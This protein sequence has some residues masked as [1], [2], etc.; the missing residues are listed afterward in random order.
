MKAP[1]APAMM[2]LSEGMPDGLASM[3]GDLLERA[4]ALSRS[5]VLAA[6]P[7]A[8]ILDVAERAAIVEV[9]AGAP[10]PVRTDAGDAVLVIATGRVRVGDAELG[11]GALIG[12]LAAVD[13]DAAPPDAIAVEPT[14]AIRIWQDDFL[15]LLA[16]HPA[17]ARTLARELAAALRRRTG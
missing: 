2:S 9:A 8:A 6:V 15:D 11:P 14:A 3:S 16:E 1:G 7:A 5:P 13:D 10:V 17:A 4:D 12:E